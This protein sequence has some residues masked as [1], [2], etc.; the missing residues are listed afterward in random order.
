MNL[1]KARVFF[2]KVCSKLLVTKINKIKKYFKK[3]PVT[4]NKVTK[5]NNASSIVFTAVNIFVLDDFVYFPT[6]Q[7]IINRRLLEHYRLMFLI[8]VL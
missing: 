3:I 7:R 2:N 6:H 5:Q 1:N 4:L 8:D